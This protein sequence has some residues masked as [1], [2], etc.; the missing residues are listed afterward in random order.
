MSTEK[1]AGVDI[2]TQIEKRSNFGIK[3][4]K[5][6]KGVSCFIFSFENLWVCFLKVTEQGI[7]NKVTILSIGRR[8]RLF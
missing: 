5:R 1:H 3:L 4:L 7:Q 8:G 6:H 2:R